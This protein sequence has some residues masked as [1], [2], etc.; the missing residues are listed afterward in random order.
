MNPWR[1]SGQERWLKGAH[2]RL[3]PQRALSAIRIPGMDSPGSESDP[4]IAQIM[5]WV[6][7][8]RVWL[9]R[10]RTL[11]PPPGSYS[12]PA[13]KIRYVR[14]NTVM[15]CLLGPGCVKI[16]TVTLCLY[17]IHLIC[18]A[19]PIDSNCLLALHGSAAII[20]ISA[21]GR[22]LYVRIWRV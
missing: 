10:A 19:K 16:S 1:E 5:E 21:R 20:T 12:Q 15:L 17:E 18:C 4:K 14:L 7:S 2:S 6:E 13:L 22:S 9:I 3:D 11:I 8:G